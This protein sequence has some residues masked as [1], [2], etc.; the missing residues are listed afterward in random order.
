MQLLSSAEALRS[1]R[2]MHNITGF[3]SNSIFLKTDDLLMA[4][5]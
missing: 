5:H 1:L 4:M 2:P 3:K